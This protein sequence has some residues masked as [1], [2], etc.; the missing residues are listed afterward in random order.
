MIFL[1]VTITMLKSDVWYQK[2]GYDLY[3]IKYGIYSGEKGNLQN[4]KHGVQD[5][6]VLQC[7]VVYM[8]IH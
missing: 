8:Y 4:D 2:V 5:V 3:P 6:I 1:F 7:L